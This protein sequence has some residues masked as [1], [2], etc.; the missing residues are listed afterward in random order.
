MALARELDFLFQKSNIPVGA[1][2]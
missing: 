1:R 2:Y